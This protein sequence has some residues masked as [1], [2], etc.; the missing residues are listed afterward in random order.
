VFHTTKDGNIVLEQGLGVIFG[1][2][3]KGAAGWWTK[4]Y[5]ESCFICTGHWILVGGELKNSGTD[6]TRKTYCRDTPNLKFETL[7]EVKL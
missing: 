6:G 1:L 5:I 3:K 4:L 7:K 2:N